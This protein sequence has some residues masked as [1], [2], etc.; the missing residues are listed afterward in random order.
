MCEQEETIKSMGRRKFLVL[1]HHSIY[2]GTVFRDGNSIDHL[3]NCNALDPELSLIK[4]VV[5]TMKLKLIN[6]PNIVPLIFE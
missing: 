6:R 2:Y 1:K 5:E 4:N 3:W